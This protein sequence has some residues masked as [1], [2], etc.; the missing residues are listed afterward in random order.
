[1]GPTTERRSPSVCSRSVTAASELS[2]RS[3][4]PP[5]ATHHPS[6]RICAS[7]AALPSK[8]GL[9]AA[10]ACPHR[11]VLDRVGA[12]ILDV[13]EAGAAA[14]IDDAC[15]SIPL[16]RRFERVL[17]ILLERRHQHKEMDGIACECHRYRVGFWAHDG[18]RDR[19]GCVYRPRNYRRPSLA[20]REPPA[21][22]E[23]WV[24][25]PEVS[26]CADVL[27]G[28]WV[29]QLRWYTLD[30]LAPDGGA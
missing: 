7:I 21:D 24:G 25:V 2:I 27:G 20:Q 26:W 16:A 5:E 12:A 30:E 6:L 17:R 28:Q 22:A 14:A 15:R 8:A 23:W 13:W 11:S 19:S 4:P 1:M 3:H 10:G 18:V 29:S 9:L